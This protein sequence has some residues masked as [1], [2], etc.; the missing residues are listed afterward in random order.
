MLW[1][2]YV[3]SLVDVG[4]TVDEIHEHIH[5]ST[6]ACNQQRS[7]SILQGS[8]NMNEDHTR[9][10]YR[11]VMMRSDEFLWPDT[12]SKPLLPSLAA[13]DL[14]RD[15]NLIFAINLCASLQGLLH[16]AQLTV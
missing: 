16:S 14:N 3:I 9:Q 7:A 13:P 1:D 11:R 8:R 15:T 10:E 5:V 4:A 12:H 2:T 6:F